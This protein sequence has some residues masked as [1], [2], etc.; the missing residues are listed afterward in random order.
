M[1][2]GPTGSATAFGVAPEEGEARWFLGELLTVKASAESTGGGLSLFD[3]RAPSGPASPLHVHRGEAEWWYVLEGELVVWAA[4]Q[5]A[6]APAGS[7]VYSPPDTPHTFSVV[8]DEARFLLGTNPGG[9]EAFL[10]ACSEPAGDRTLP[11]PETAAPDPARLA[12]LA[13]EHGIEIL[14]P[15]G[16]PG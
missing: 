2:A 11:P 1:T 15:P 12:E 6:E 8:S 3:V 14:G 13:A 10:R 4:G 5:V 16:I 9:F 7:F